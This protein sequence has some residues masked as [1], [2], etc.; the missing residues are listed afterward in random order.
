MEAVITICNSILLI[1]N[2]IIVIRNGK[3][4]DRIKELLLML[5]ESELESRGAVP[6]ELGK[7][8]KKVFS[9]ADLYDD[10]Y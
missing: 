1:F 10:I 2:L 4:S 9:W 8:G 5:M 6:T 3:V 7:E